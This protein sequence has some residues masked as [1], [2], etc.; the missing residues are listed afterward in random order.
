MDSTRNQRALSCT[1]VPVRDN[2]MFRGLSYTWKLGLPSMPGFRRPA[3][4]RSSDQYPYQV[5]T[6]RAFRW[7]AAGREASSDAGTHSVQP[8]VRDNFSPCTGML[9]SLF[10]VPCSWLHA[11][12][13]LFLLIVRYRTA[14][15]VVPC[16]CQIIF[17]ILQRG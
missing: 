10:C 1:A 7:H 17:V 16:F 9:N 5:P 8:D 13:I 15:S 11:G 3:S 4:N 14:W 2:V 12:M 6:R